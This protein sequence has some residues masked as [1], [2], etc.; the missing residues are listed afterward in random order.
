VEV[1]MCTYSICFI[2]L[3]AAVVLVQ[4]VEC[5]TNEEPRTLEEPLCRFVQSA[6]SQS[7]LEPEAIARLQKVD[8]LAATDPDLRTPLGLDKSSPANYSNSRADRELFES[9]LVD[10]PFFEDLAR[11]Q[12]AIMWNLLTHCGCKRDSVSIPAS[13]FSQ[14]NVS[15]RATFVGITHA[16]LNTHLVDRENGK[17]LGN[18]LQLIEG[19][20]ALRGENI[21]LP[22]DQQFQLIVRLAPAA[23]Q[24]L[25][26]AA[27]FERGEN[28]VFHKGYPISFRQFRRIGLQGQEAGLHISLVPDGRLAE[29]HIDY[30]FGL[31]HLG[32][33]NADVRA[34]GNHERHTDR[35]PNFGFVVRLVRVRRAVL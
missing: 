17:D 30:R 2:T 20:L 21:A 12:Q 35:W 1:P 34:P 28:H 24:R 23:L 22:S 14:F 8:L 16:M 29:I 4:P 9:A 18:A 26:R 11:E 31:L 5:A 32:P 19:L 6:A 15:Q 25:D 10:W 27:S 33:A 13:V 7:Q 3:L